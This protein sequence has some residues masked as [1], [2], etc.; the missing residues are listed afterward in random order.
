MSIED[1][2][3]RL[4]PIEEFLG[5]HSD[6]DLE[7]IVEEQGFDG[8]LLEAVFGPLIKQ[9]EEQLREVGY[10]VL[11]DEVEDWF[12]HERAKFVVMNDGLMMPRMDKRDDRFAD[13]FDNV[14]AHFDMP[15]KVIIPN[16]KHQ[17]LERVQAWVQ[18]TEN[19]PVAEFLVRTP[20]EY[21]KLLIYYAKVNSLKELKSLLNEFSVRQDDIS[22]TASPSYKGG[23]M[24]VISQSPVEFF[25]ALPG[26]LVEEMLKVANVSSL[27]DYVNLFLRAPYMTR[28]LGSVPTSLLMYVLKKANANSV[29]SV[30]K[31]LENEDFRESLMSIDSEGSYPQNLV[32]AMEHFKIDDL[33]GMQEIIGFEKTRAVMKKASDV[34]FKTLVRVADPATADELERLCGNTAVV[35]NIGEA[36]Y[37][38][39]EDL[40]ADLGVE[41]EKRDP[42]MYEVIT[43]SYNRKTAEQAKTISS[44]LGKKDAIP[45]NLNNFVIGLLA[46]E[47][48]IEQNLDTVAQLLEV[49]SLVTNETVEALRALQK[50]M[51]GFITPELSKRYLAAD[52]DNGKSEVLD[53][54]RSMMGQVLSSKKIEI[55]DPNMAAEI[56]YL[57]YRPTGYSIEQVRN[58]IGGGWNS[59]EDLTH[60]LDS[61][62][63]S[64]DGYDMRFNRVEREQREPYDTEG[65][66]G[67]D[68][69][70]VSPQSKLSLKDLL[71]QALSGKPKHQEALPQLF[72]AV[73]A[74]MGDDRVVAYGENYN[75][76]KGVSAEYTEQRLESLGEIL[77]IIPKEDPFREALSQL[78]FSDEEARRTCDGIADA[79]QWKRNKRHFSPEERTCK[80]RVDEILKHLSAE[81]DSDVSA[82]L[83]PEVL[84][85]LD[86]DLQGLGGQDLYDKLS[87]IKNSRFLRRET[88]EESGV[89]TFYSA[90]LDYAKSGSSFLRREMRKVEAVK[91][92]DTEEV[93]AVVSK[94]V[95]SY[96]AKAGA[97]ICTSHN[98][99]MWNEERH[100]H[101]NLVCGDQ[102]IGN[103]MLYF[104][105]ERDYLVARGFNP[106]KDAMMKFD[107]YSMAAQITAVLEEIA[108]S[109]GY[110]EIFVPEQTAWHALSN[111]D[112]M[113]KE[114]ISIS[115][116]NSSR[117]SEA[118]SEQ[119]TLIEDA[120]FYVTE[121]GGH[122]I[123]R[124]NLLTQV[125]L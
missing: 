43:H 50:I 53:S 13:N 118:D 122:S 81:I 80:N 10:R 33:E 107:R 102:I 38:P 11:S 36:D 35:Q 41:P 72:G 123:N 97:E 121:N 75:S 83:D 29:E 20:A 96:F 95:G 71:F 3:A 113:A 34:N 101:L 22:E 32:T 46:D 120:E 98:T 42:Y 27:E 61:I 116:R 73:L 64:R 66:R 109:N 8:L 115:K 15:G 89:N 106:R 19:E 67:I 24:S 94:N 86:E 26:R 105:P 1:E 55:E 90:L 2:S 82:L 77:S 104:E 85:P 39:L 37:Q 88:E 91:S 100:A 23:H 111:R 93:K 7:R 52:G 6:E 18:R 87:A 63:F 125:K 62:S 103:V 12:L 31:V 70:I 60:H 48:Y 17:K 28:L 40:L 21:L 108:R 114:I 112:G 119:R 45:D 78:I 54:Y 16:A 9:A 69:P 49:D 74:Q 57:A 65:L 5:Q 58:M 44:L 51:G 99:R 47:D 25:T 68:A 79:Y 56:I 14:L 117:V 124:L 110:K 4:D 30:I 76:G 92:E 59:L 84:A